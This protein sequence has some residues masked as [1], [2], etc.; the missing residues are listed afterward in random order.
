MIVFYFFSCV[1]FCVEGTFDS[2][3]LLKLGRGRVQTADRHIINQNS[4]VEGDLGLIITGI[5]FSFKSWLDLKFL[6]LD[7]FILIIRDA[8]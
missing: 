4:A 1:S 8:Q 6:Y 2:R 7:L 5:F 3:L